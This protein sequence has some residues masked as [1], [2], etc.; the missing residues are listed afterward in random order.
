MSYHA[1]LYHIIFRPHKNKP[2]ITEQYERDLYA[3]INALVRKK[4]YVLHRINSMPD[5]IHLLISLPPSACI[6]DFVRDL[7]IATHSFMK[8]NKDKFPHFEKW[9]ESFAVL[10]YSMGQKD[11]VYNYIKNQKEHHKRISFADELRNLLE[12]EG[13][14]YNEHFFLA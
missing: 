5:H 8:N 2:V 6:S 14:P 4:G 13:I 3:Y 12:E 10:S 7:K 9:A 1:L 11:T